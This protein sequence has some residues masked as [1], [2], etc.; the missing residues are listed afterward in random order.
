[1]QYTKVTLKTST[2]KKKETT[3]DEILGQ[4]GEITGSM[5]NVRKTEKINNQKEMRN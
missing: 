1:M 3:A 4:R 5:R 2:L